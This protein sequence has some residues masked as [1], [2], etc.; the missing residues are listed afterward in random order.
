M[1]FRNAILL[2]ALSLGLSAGTS[3]A[4]FITTYPVQSGYYGYSNSAIY[5]AAYA[6]PAIGYS[7]YSMQNGIDFNSG[8]SNGFSNVYNNGFNNGFSNIY[9]NGFSGYNLSGYNNLWNNI[10]GYRGNGF[11]NGFRR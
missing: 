4:Q 1:T 6:A 8:F 9:N 5:P 7:G 3:H 11:R 10:S 2:A